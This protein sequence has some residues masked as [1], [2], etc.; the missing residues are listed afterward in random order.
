[1]N[2]RRNHT[3][4]GY[5]LIEVVLALGL[6]LFTLSLLY[7]IYVRETQA[8]QVRENMLDAQQRARVVVDVMSRELLGAG[9]D[10]AGLNHDA[11]PANDFWGV[12]L[13]ATGLQLLADFNG[14]GLLNDANESIAFSL[15]SSSHILRRNTGGGN[16]PFAEDIESFQVRLLDQGGSQTV[17]PTEVRAVELT[18]T[19]R[20]AKPDPLYAHNG[21]FRTVTLQERVTPRNLIQ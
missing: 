5:T 8:Q 21:G 12:S 20:T 7:A 2:P 10:P 14:N 19:A 15:D 6:S 18:V 17:V 1:M 16:Q 11:N 4:G 9:Y 13:G 3:T